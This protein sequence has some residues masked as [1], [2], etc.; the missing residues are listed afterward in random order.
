[1]LLHHHHLRISQREKEGI[2][3]L[4][5]DG[6][7]EMGKGDIVLRDYAD[8]LLAQGNRQLILDLERVSH[9]DTAGSGV[10]LSLAQKCQA[11]GG[12]MALFNVPRAHGEVYEMA[13]LETVVEIYSSEID[14]VNSFFPD[15]NPPHYDILEYVERLQSHEDHKDKE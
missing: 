6:R 14:A 2:T 8:S 12:R 7:L 13:R 4:E 3:I 10:L 9:I 5:L 11:A 15:R 1:M